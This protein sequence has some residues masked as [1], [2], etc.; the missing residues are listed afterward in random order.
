LTLF[1]VSG[2][3]GILRDTYLKV[4]G[5]G[6]APSLR[7]HFLNG[8]YVLPTCDSDEK[9]QEI[10]Y[11]LLTTLSK[12][13]RLVNP[14][15]AL[16]NLHQTTEALIC[17][18]F[19]DGYRDVYTVIAPVLARLKIKAIFFINPSFLGMEKGATRYVLQK[20]YKT[21]ID[22]TFMTREMVAALHQ[23]G[24]VI[25]SHS[26]SHQRLNIEDEDVLLNEIVN[27]KIEIEKI[28]QDKCIHFAYP[29]GGN[30]DLSNEALDLAMQNYSYIYSSIKRDGLWSFNGRVINRRHFEGNWPVSHIRYFLSNRN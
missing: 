27:S 5:R 10:F 7:T 13:N 26:T 1:N 24:H 6:A 22:K 16:S 23:Q 17:L 4:M 30:N 29:F 21:T 18:T 8:H 11:R 2:V 19:D 3:K 12:N 15:E 9:Q 25:G 14:D 28:T 20:N